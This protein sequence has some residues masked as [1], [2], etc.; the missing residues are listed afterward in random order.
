MSQSYAMCPCCGR[1]IIVGEEVG[2]QK[3]LFHEK[4]T[5]FAEQRGGEV[6]FMRTR[7]LGRGRG[8]ESIPEDADPDL[9]ELVLHTFADRCRRFLEWYD[10]RE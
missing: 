7:G 5:A 4:L 6:W 3:S 9:M 2:A 10:G 1:P 8:F